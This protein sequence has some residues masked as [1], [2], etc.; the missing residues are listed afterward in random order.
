M[1]TLYIIATPIGNLGDITV[2]ALET[3]R[4]VD[5]I[6]CEDTRVTAILLAHAGISKP[7]FAYHQHSS[8]KVVA[9]IALSL[10]EGMSVAVVSDAGTPGVNDPGGRLIA[11]L[12]KALP[13]LHIVPLPGPNAAIAAL[14]VSGFPADRYQYWGFV[15]HKKGRVTFFREL[16]LCGDTVVFYESK[17]R[18]VKTLVA[19]GE[20]CPDRMLVV[21]REITKKFETFYRGTASDIVPRIVGDDARG[22]FVIVAAPRR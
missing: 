13:H 21:A 7:L 1:G 15:P 22:E 12:L 18:I 16:A 14:S 3:L 20:V 4:T 6:F 8:Q 11:D 2:R 10:N 19:L 5:A 9:D 17:H